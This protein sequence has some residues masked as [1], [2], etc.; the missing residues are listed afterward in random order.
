MLLAIDV[1]NTNVTIG[2]FEGERLVHHWRLAAL[3]ERTADELPGALEPREHGRHVQA[4][5][6]LEQAPFAGAVRAGAAA[7]EPLH[8]IRHVLDER[9]R[10]PAGR[11]R[12]VTKSLTAASPGSAA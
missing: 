1:G 12:A 3:R 9:R 10:Q 5:A 11:D 2:V 7:H 4:V 6:R 8:R